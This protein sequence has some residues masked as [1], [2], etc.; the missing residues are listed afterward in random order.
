MM[1]SKKSSNN[2]GTSSKWCK[3]DVYIAR[4]GDDLSD[5]TVWALLILWLPLTIVYHHNLEIPHYLLP[6][7]EIFIQYDSD[8]RFVYD[9]HW[10]WPN[11]AHAHTHKPTFQSAHPKKTWGFAL[12]SK[13]VVLTQQH[14]LC[15]ERPFCITTVVWYF[16]ELKGLFHFNGLGT[17]LTQ[18]LREKTR[19]KQG[20]HKETCKIRKGHKAMRELNEGRSQ[21]MT[22]F[23][24]W[25]SFPT[26]TCRIGSE[27]LVNIIP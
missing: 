27:T 1:P 4:L 21:T 15:I 3:R 25:R 22:S 24:M 9:H 5:S 20:R 14:M 10:S 18:I 23:W 11:P 6:E 16:S 17:M 26:K 12:G 2:N 19:P 7:Y 8:S 13:V